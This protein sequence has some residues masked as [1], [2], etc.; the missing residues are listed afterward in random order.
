MRVVLCPVCGWFE[1]Y[2]GPMDAPPEAVELPLASR[3]RRIEARLDAVEQRSQDQDRRVDARLD[4][5]DVRFD[6]V[7]RRFK[8]LDKRVDGTDRR[9][10][11]LRADYRAI[12]DRID[13]LHTTAA[14]RPVRTGVTPHG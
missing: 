3:I 6:T 10:D 9:M 13:A 14:F 5:V 8:E 11:E 1:G 2:R 4:V 12:S 7:D